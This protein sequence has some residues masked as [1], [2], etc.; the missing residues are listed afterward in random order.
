MVR[1]KQAIV[2]EGR[3]DRNTLLQIVDA[4]VFCTNGFG[5]MNDPALLRL[6]R[7]AAEK[8]G[9]VILTDSDAAGFVIRNYLKSCLPNKRLLHAYVP[10]V[11]GKETRK[12]APGKEGKLGVEGMPP[13][14]ILQALRDAGAELDGACT[15]RPE[16]AIT[17]QDLYALG[18]SGGARS[19][20]R[21]AELLQA[22][23]LPEHMSANA[24][25]QA[26]NLRFTREAFFARFG[27]TEEDT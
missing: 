21:R 11:A 13:Q 17:K 14:V 10:D 25:L 26:L 22:L 8:R 24:L 19:R 1:V 5:V 4:P 20:Q 23:R 2:V 12:R 16:T 15:D 9:L 7:E 27:K 18:L 6:L 3:Y